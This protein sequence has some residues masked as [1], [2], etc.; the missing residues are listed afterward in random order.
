[1]ARCVSEAVTASNQSTFLQVCKSAR[2]AGHH[3]IASGIIRFAFSY[4][5]GI[6]IMNRMVVLLVA[7]GLAAVLADGTLALYGDDDPTSGR[8][9]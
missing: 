8:S 4:P 7:Q 1:M 5:R 9:T 2:T 6:I 3:G